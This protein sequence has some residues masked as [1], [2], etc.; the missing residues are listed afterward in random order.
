MIKMR[1][2]V[3]EKPEPG[4]VL[5]EVQMNENLEAD[6]VLV[7]IKNVSIC[8]TDLH[9]Y[10]WD[11]WSQKK[12]KTPQ[13]DGHE[14]VG[15]VADIGSEVSMV[16]KGDTVVSETHIPC[17]H[18]IQCRTGRMHVCKN[19]EILG[20]DRDGVFA[21]YVKVPEIVLWKIDESIPID[22][23]SVME[24]FGNAIHT[25]LITELTG[26]NVLI[27]GAGPIG[28]MAIAIVKHAGAAKVIVSEPKEYRIELA[29]KMGADF[30]INPQTEDMIDRV[31]KNTDGNGVDVLLEM[32]GNEKAFRDGLEVVTNGGEVSLLGVFAGNLSFDINGLFTFKGLTLHGITGRKMF[33]TWNIATNLLKNKIIDLS[34]VVTHKFKLEDWQKGFEIMNKGESGK[35]ILQVE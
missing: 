33:E 5:K 1:A 26:K 7:K 9:I 21:E 32:S 34:P 4:F 30:I 12:I 16:K 20:V 15:E 10:R 8:G 17:K 13:I 31:L 3:K 18:C 25:S 23:A 24:P 35:V 28:A 19:L 11:E 6:E 27:T 22:F 14:F 2:L 29:K